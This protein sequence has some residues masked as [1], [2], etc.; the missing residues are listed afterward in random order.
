[1]SK[2]YERKLSRTNL[3]GGNLVRAYLSSL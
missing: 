2:S 1:M 3:T